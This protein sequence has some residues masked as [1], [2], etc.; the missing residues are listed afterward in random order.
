MKTTHPIPPLPRRPWR[1]AGLLLAALVSL[2]GHI[3]AQE[4]MLQ[5]SL[6]DLVA[7]AEWITVA[8]LVG[9]QPHRNARGNLIVTDYRFRRVQAW[10]GATPADFVLTQGG[11]TLAGETHRISDTPV[12][13]V[14]QR[15]LLFVRPGRGEMF[16]PFVGGAQGAWLLTGTN[17]ALSLGLG[18]ETL[19][20][21]ELLAQVDALVT[22]RGA[23][24]PRS[25]VQGSMPAGSYP[26]KA[27]RPLALTPPTTPAGVPPA[28]AEA[29]VGPR[30]DGT[31][32]GRSMGGTPASAGGDGIDY[33]Y[34]HRIAP[35]AVINSFPHDWTPWY[36]EDQYQMAK[37]NQHGGDVLRV[38]TT[39]TGD[40]AWQNDRF[41]LAGWPSNDDMVAQFGE[42]WGANT[43]GI[44]Y[45][46]W[47]GDGAIVEA[48]VALNPAFCWTMDERVALDANQSCWGYR[49]TLLHELGHAWGLA[50]PWE[51]QSVWW[52]SVMNYSPK[53]YRYAYLFTDDTNAVRAAFA[54]P[55]IHDALLG[56]YTTAVG[57]ASGALYSATQAATID[58]RHGEDLA[59]W[60]GRQFKIENLGTDDVVSPSVEFYLS[61]QRMDWNAGYVFLGSASYA[62]VP[63]YST[64]TFWMPFLPV[65]ASTPTGDY[66]LAAYLPGADANMD[67][68]SAWADEDVRVRVHNN[69]ALL[70][71]QP[72][73]QLSGQGV[74]GPQGDWWFEF[75]GEAGASYQFSLCPE[76]GG[77]AAFDTTLSIYQADSELAYDD[78]T[79]GL[80]SQLEWTAP[81]SAT[82]R[83]RVGSYLDAEEGA[84]QLGYRR[85]IDDTLFGNGFDG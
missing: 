31:G 26:A 67:N 47:F 63:T 18:H 53:N 65:S 82:F 1:A 13:E 17:G 38:Y 52:D 54:G 45:S 79:C 71:P 70:V 61:R 22:A 30:A 5:K 41:D 75:A 6:P 72:A 84:F 9:A 81:Y 37:W 73:W 33:H 56:L 58:V 10:L 15:Y 16:A 3:G 74:L 51:T 2:A 27:W 68:N 78:D 49:Q 55:A 69:P 60:V 44:T 35:P 48:D 11:G 36:P 77:W 40:W 21:D 80:Q 76:S 24:P 57:G 23:A 83:I 50:H 34:E 14:G 19:A 66:W 62:S 43:L 64:W 29:M 85:E 59:A 8:D 42:G 39:P 20:R 12:L 32:S 7:E 25:P 28:M 4:L 46:R